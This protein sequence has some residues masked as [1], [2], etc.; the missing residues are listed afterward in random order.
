MA[1]RARMECGRQDSNLHGRLGAGGL[2][3]V[4]CPASPKAAVYANSTTPA[5]TV[6]TSDNFLSGFSDARLC[7]HRSRGNHAAALGALG[8]IAP[9]YPAFSLEDRVNDF[10]RS[11]DAQVVQLVARRLPV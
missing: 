1:D 9:I 8:R 11:R 7:Q 10:L 6:A 5:L 4:W 3:K 2:A